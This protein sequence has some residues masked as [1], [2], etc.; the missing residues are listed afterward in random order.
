LMFFLPMFP[1]P[2]LLLTSLLVL[3]ALLSTDTSI[4]L[5]TLRPLSGSLV[6][7]VIVSSVLSYSI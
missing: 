7:M 5:M 3:I 4:P 2:I 6:T 1:V